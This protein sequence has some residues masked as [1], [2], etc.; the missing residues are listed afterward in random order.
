MASNLKENTKKMKQIN[1]YYIIILIIALLIL[2][3]GATVAYFTVVASQDKDA[4]QIRTGT[5][6]VKFTDGIEINNPLLIPRN[7]PSGVDDVEY[8]YK[9]K[10]SV[11]S[12]GSLDQTID[13]FVDITSNSFT[14]NA[15]KYRVYNSNGTPI[16][17]G[18]VSKSGS[19]KVVENTYLKSQATAEYTLV[20]WLQET[21]VSQNDNQAKSLIGTMKVEAVQVRK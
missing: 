21:G 3:V 15:L 1:L 7:E 20:I 10:F 19:V 13:V 17:E 4:T 2:V 16:K 9:N 6:I 12:T 5:L 11:E 14:E 8:L 18:S